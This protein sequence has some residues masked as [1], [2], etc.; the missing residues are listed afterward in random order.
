MS[1]GLDGSGIESLWG[2]RFSSPVQTGPEAHPYNYLY[3]EQWVSFPRAWPWPPTPPIYHRGVL[4]K[5]EFYLYLYRLI[6][7]VIGINKPQMFYYRFPF[8]FLSL[9][10]SP[11]ALLPSYLPIL[12]YFF[13]SVTHSVRNILCSGYIQHHFKI[14]F[15]LWHVS[16]PLWQC[17][18]V[19]QWYQPEFCTLHSM[20]QGSS[21]YEYS[22][23]LL[24]FPV[25]ART[26]FL[27][28][29]NE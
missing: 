17:V 22:Q 4:F 6:T 15:K 24:F 13:V 5:G 21:E 10:P 12:L 28:K 29:T 11:S 20:D 23:I 14:P 8:P 19:F 1:Y 26:K 3:N 9:V 27:D 2:A 16:Q 7:R 25:S 18:A